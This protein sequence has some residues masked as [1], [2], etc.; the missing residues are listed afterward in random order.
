M[1]N[2]AGHRKRFLTALFT[3]SVLFTFCFAGKPL[4]KPL[5]EGYTL[6]F[7]IPVYSNGVGDTLLKGSRSFAPLLISYNVLKP[8]YKVNCVLTLGNTLVGMSTLT[9]DAPNYLFD[10]ISNELHGQGTIQLQAYP[11]D[12]VSTLEGDFYVVKASKDTVRFKGTIT[13]WYSTSVR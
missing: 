13:G 8:G 5:Q 1:H 11:P 6:S 2:T 7:K 4:H 9:S 3:T 12:Q 10:V